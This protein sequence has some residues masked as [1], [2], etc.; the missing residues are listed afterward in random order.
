MT[1]AL[2]MSVVCDLLEEQWPSMDLL[3]EMLLTHAG[4]DER[5]VAT[6]VRPMLAPR[7]SRLPLLSGRE[8]F[9]FNADRILNRMW[10]VPRA[11]RRAVKDSDVFHVCDHSYAYA[12][13]AL[14]TERVGVYCHDLDA[15]RCLLEPRQEPRPLWFRAMSRR[16]LEGLKKARVVFFSTSAVRDSILRYGLIDERKLVQA[17]YGVS[18]EFCPDPADV[19]PADHPIHG[20]EGRPFLLHV[21]SCIPR[22]RIDVLLDVFAQVHRENP[23]VR[24]IQVGGAWTDDQ[25]AQL[26]R[27]GLARF[28]VQL[29]RAGRTELAKFY[30]RAAMVLMPS[31]AEGFGLPVIEALSCGAMV[32]ASDIPTLREAGGDAVSFVPV[33][34]LPAWTRV[35]SE[36]LRDASH[37]PPRE[38]RL[39][40]SGQFSWAAHAK[41]I[42]D[43]YLALS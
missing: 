18:P 4:R 9:A 2:R 37:A 33:A 14:P 30:R 16:L 12:V 26:E 36:L 20:L 40:H 13:H 8:R 21:G 24:L 10:D 15:F 35:V 5:V 32:V 23:E 39:T 28:L 41:V 17:R 3:A 7:V 29:P 42:I 27:L 31:D 19:L 1:R 25:R 43:T 38:R 11:A 34:D 22:K 6:P